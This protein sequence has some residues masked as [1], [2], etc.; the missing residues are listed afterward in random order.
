VASAVSVGP[1]GPALLEASSSGLPLSQLLPIVV[2]QQNPLGKVDSLMEIRHFLAQSIYL[3][4]E[5]RIVA[6]LDPAPQTLGQ[7][8]AYRADGKEEESSSSEDERDGK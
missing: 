5:L 8:L 6:W 1:V 2:F 3:R 7:S 4:Q